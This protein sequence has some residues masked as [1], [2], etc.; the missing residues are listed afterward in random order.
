MKIAQKFIA[1]IGEL[2]KF[3][4]FLCIRHLSKINTVFSKY[5]EARE[6]K[7]FAVVSH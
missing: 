7:N 1:G 2:K 3:S 5:L 6:N 4:C